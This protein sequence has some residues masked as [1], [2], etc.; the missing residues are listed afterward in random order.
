MWLP[1]FSLRKYSAK[2]YELVRTYVNY[3]S[4]TDEIDNN[5]T[6]QKEDGIA[7]VELLSWILRMT[8]TQN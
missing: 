3:L 4:V 7:N 5:I 2:I 8:F 1:G 6:T